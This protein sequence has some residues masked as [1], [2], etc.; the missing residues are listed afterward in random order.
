MT[1]SN[2]FGQPVNPA[3]WDGKQVFHL[4][5]GGAT[6]MPPFPTAPQYLFVYEDEFQDPTT[7]EG[8]ME[9]PKVEDQFVIYPTVPG[10]PDYSPI[11]H[12]Q[13]VLVSRD[14]EPNSIRSVDE[15]MASGLRIEESSIWIN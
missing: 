14:Y 8:F 4:F 11:W 13:W 5:V 6:E 2:P 7:I 15:L 9:Q 12:N 1:Y 10:Q 3:W